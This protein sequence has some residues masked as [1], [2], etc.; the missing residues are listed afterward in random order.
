M[1]I[2]GYQTERPNLQQLSELLCQY[3]AKNKNI[4]QVTNMFLKYFKKQCETSYIYQK[5]QL[6]TFKELLQKLL[7]RLINHNIT[8]EMRDYDEMYES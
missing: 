2:A 7:M 5:L 4:L 3:N 8:V 6:L 1:K